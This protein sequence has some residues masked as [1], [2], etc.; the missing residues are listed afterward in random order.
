[1]LKQIK[2]ID[3]Y[4]KSQ[5]IPQYRTF[6]TSNAFVVVPAAADRGVN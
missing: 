2:K 6:N 5:R 4:R 3:L 1:M